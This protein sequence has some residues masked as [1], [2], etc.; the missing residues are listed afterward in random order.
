MELS[1]LL[2]NI[3]VMGR[4]GILTVRQASLNECSEIRWERGQE[5][6]KRKNRTSSESLGQKWSEVNRGFSPQLYP[7]SLVT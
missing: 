3:A 7:V 1:A 6:K 5:K 2:S 4:G